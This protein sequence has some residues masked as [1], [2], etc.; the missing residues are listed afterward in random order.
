[1]IEKQEF[2]ALAAKG[3]EKYQYDGRYLYRSDSKSSQS[4]SQS[5]I[6][7]AVSACILGAAVAA[8]NDFAVGIDAFDYI[9]TIFKIDSNYTYKIACASNGAGSKEAALK[10]VEAIEWPVAS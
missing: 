1:M 4:G 8:A 5:T 3:W 10:A 6:P 7:N 2:L 9:H